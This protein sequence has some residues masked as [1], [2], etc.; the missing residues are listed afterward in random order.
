MASR[1]LES[2]IPTSA[3]NASADLQP[4]LSNSFFAQQAQSEI[5]RADA[6]AEAARIAAANHEDFT[7]ILQQFL[8]VSSGLRNISRKF[9][10]VSKFTDEAMRQLQFA[11]QGAGNQPVDAA[12]VSAPGTAGTPAPAPGTPGAPERAPLLAGTQDM[13]KGGAT[14]Q[15]IPPSQRA[16]SVPASAVPTPGTTG[17]TSPAPDQSRGQGVSSVPTGAQGGG[18]FTLSGS[19]TPPDKGNGAAM[20]LSGTQSRNAMVDAQ[21]NYHF[22]GLPNGQYTLTPQKPGVTFTPQSVPVLINSYN[23]TGVNFGAA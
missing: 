10:E 12:G 22:D 9:P 11:M 20:Q 14:V 4:L 8:N 1:K 6:A 2:L 19:I 16:A 21:G 17:T 7:G 13:A 23:Q 5:D 3:P 15:D 18:V